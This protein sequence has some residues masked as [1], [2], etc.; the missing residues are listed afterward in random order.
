MCN[1]KLQELFMATYAIIK[2]SRLF[3]N[4]TELVY[5]NKELLKHALLY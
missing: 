4:G 2:I 5:I 1:S 3:S